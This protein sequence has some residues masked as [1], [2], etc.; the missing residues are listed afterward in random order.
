MPGKN[1]WS[2]EACGVRFLTRNH[3]GPFIFGVPVAARSE[4]LS[5][6]CSVVG[7]GWNG[8]RAGGAVVAKSQ[9]KVSSHGVISPK[10]D[11]SNCKSPSAIART[12]KLYG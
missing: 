10:I 5:L 2:T 8:A 1:C 12:A 11:H 3:T 9:S 7:K 4:E 6:S